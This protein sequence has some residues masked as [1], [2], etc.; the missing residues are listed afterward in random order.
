M[1]VKTWIS[2]TESLEVE[3]YADM[4]YDNGDFSYSG[5]HCT[6]GVG[7]VGNSGAS[8]Q[9]D[10]AIQYDESKYTKQEIEIIDLYLTDN[11]TMI[12]NKLEETFWK[13]DL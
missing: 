4:H 10:G 5:T 9:L 3:V 13:N 8:V 2:I 6:H 7:G 1:K 11:E 12:C